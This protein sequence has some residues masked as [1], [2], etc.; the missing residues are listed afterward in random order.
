MR[1]KMIRRYIKILPS[2]AIAVVLIAIISWAVIQKPL[3]AQES[4]LP[5]EDPIPFYIPSP[6]S[7]S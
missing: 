2:L 3:E 7:Y 6:S 1:S 5:Q 4:S